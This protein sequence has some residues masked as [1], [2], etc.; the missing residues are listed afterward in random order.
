MLAKHIMQ[1]LALL[2]LCTT[3]Y[4]QTKVDED[5]VSW[6]LEQDLENLLPIG[7]TKFYYVGYQMRP[8]FIQL[9]ENLKRAAMNQEEWYLDFRKRASENP[10]LE[11]DP[12]FDLTEEE[13]KMLKSQDDGVEKVIVDSSFVEIGKDGSTY[14]FQAEGYASQLN[15]VRL[16]FKRHL[17]LTDFGEIPY[18]ST[19][20]IKQENPTGRWKGHSFHYEAGDSVLTDISTYNSTNYKFMIGQLSEDKR[21]ILFYTCY[22]I[23]NG[24]K[25][26]KADLVITYD[27]LE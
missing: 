3:C 17:V 15:T 8:E 16:D 25:E 5:V 2:M 19:V 6:N 21:A 22:E 27:L 18:R 4:G 24:Q 10:N 11:Y 26:I 13:F 1:I 23:I 9:T 14:A 7:R 12:S 20:D